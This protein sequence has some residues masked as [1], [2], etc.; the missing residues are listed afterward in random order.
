MKGLRE[1]QI[2]IFRLGHKRHDF[3][4]E[5]TDK[6]FTLHEHSIVD[7]GRGKCKLAL[8]KSETMMALHFD[9]DAEIELTC[10]RSLEKFWYPVKLEEEIII[11]FGDDNYTLSEDVLVIKHE[12]PSINIGEFIYEFINLAVP[13]KKLHPKYE[14]EDGEQPEL[15]YTSQQDSEAENEEEQMDPRWEALKKLKGNK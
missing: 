6:L 14:D 11:K 13:M 4:Y 7:H 2:E 10:D 1:F 15:I 3:E 9:I 5:I 8:D 12:T